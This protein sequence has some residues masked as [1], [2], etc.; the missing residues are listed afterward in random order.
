MTEIH[1]PVRLSTGR[2]VIHY[3]LP[4]G[5]QAAD[6]AGSNPEMTE[7]EWLEYCE[8]LRKERTQSTAA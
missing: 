1:E 3:R 5:A 8:V 6:I 4:N 7:A 2:T